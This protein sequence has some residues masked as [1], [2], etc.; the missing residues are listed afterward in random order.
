MPGLMQI[1]LLTNTIYIH[2]LNAAVVTLYS[3]T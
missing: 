3:P 2:H 1:I